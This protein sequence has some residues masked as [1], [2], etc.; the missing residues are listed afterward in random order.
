MPRFSLSI[1]TCREVVVNAKDMR[2]AEKKAL[3]YASDCFPSTMAPIILAAT[4]C[5]NNH[6]SKTSDDADDIPRD[7]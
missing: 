2:S 3:L 6:R 1:T 4:Q 5:P 7:T